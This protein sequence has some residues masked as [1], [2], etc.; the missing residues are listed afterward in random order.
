M[1]KY[2][3]PLWSF[4]TL[5]L[6]GDIHCNPGPAHNSA[7]ICSLC[8]QEVTWSCK[9]ICCDSCDIW[10]HHSCVNVNSAEY[11]LISR[12]TV[13]WICP[14]CDSTNCDSFTFRSYALD[15]TN[16][17]SPLLNLSTVDSITSSDPF[18]PPRASSP[19]SSSCSSS[20]TSPQK[21]LQQPQQSHT[22][23]ISSSIFDIP[24]KTNLR[25]LNINFQ[26]AVGKKQELETVLQ[27]TKPD[28]IIG[29]ESWLRGVQPGKQPSPD[30]I[31]SSEVFPNY[32][33][34]FRNDR[35]TRG[36]GVF[37]LTHKSLTA[38]EQPQLVTNCEV[39][40][41][42][43]K[44]KEC[45]DLYVGAFYM[46][47]RNHRD[48]D[49]LQ[50]S[51]NKLMENGQKQRDTIIAGD[52]NCPDIE[53]STHTA[54]STGKDNDIQQKLIDN[55]SAALLTQVHHSPTRGPNILDLVFTSNPTLVKSS[56]SIPGI[57]DHNIVVTDFDTRPQITHQKPRRCFKFKQANWAQMKTDLDVAALAVAEEHK[58]GKDVDTLWSTFKAHLSETM[59]T[60]IP[61]FEFKPSQSLPWLNLS[62]KKMLKR[63]KRL[64]QRAKSSNNWTPYRHFQKHC[65]REI[66]R[67]EWR[68]ING[69]IQEGLDKNDTKPF[70][71]FIKA[72]KQDNTGVA[73]L[74]TNGQLHSDSQSKADILLEQFKSVFTKSS[75]RPLPHLKPPSPD[76]QPITIS[77]PGVA[78]LLHQLKTNKASG[79]DAIPNIV[80]KTL[81]DTIAPILTIIY[82]KSIDTAQLP[83]DWLTAN[84]SC[85]FKKGDRHIAANYRPIS[86]TSVP[87][88]ILEHII[89]RHIMS[90]LENHQILT[91][92]NHGF[93]SGF[94]TETQLLTTTNDLLK[95][96][97]QGK[98]IDMAILDF[99][100][101]F[102]TVPHDRL[103]H[104]LANY[105]ITDPLLS[106]LRCFL[107]ER[108]MQVVVEGSTSQSTTVD[109]GVPQGTVLGPL[110][111]LCHIN[112]LPE[113]VQSQVRLFADDCLIYR[114]IHNFDDH[115]T[116]QADMKNLEEWA[117]KWGMRF[118]ATKCYIMSISHSPPSHFMYTL[119]NTILQKVST[120]P[121]LGI[122]FSDNLKWSHHINGITKKANSTL[123]FLRRNLPH[124]PTA[125]KRN[126][127]LALVRPLLEY[128]AIIW[129]P[130]QKQDIEKMER[131][132]R[133]AARFIARDF[134]SATPGFV[135]GLLTKY[136]LPTL[137][138]RR[139]Q[140][141][142]VFFYKVVEGL[143]PALPPDN[144]LTPQKPGRLIRPR[145]ATI[146][147]ITQNPV[148]SYI[149]NNNRC[150]SVP[151]CKTEQYRQSFFPRT[152]IAWNHLDSLV[153]N[154]PTTENFRTALLT[155]KRQK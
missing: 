17:F 37:I 7:A 76:I 70:W 93:R 16:Y 75:S 44:L 90:H 151:Y 69:T 46:P 109:S 47:E 146:D 111:F 108:S 33:N 4:I 78:K 36:G 139:E 14:R 133:T 99:S 54:H 3:H 101:A 65:K 80:L 11:D 122:Q 38:I 135:T 61:T 56:V 153:V 13:A 116:L 34:D 138:E 143:V 92:L 20:L 148:E 22:R 79:P 72:R 155:T 127:Y 86:L 88:K 104:K 105:G 123:G 121:Y 128:G 71:R 106:W 27:Y 142:L 113:T 83:Q 8:D 55:S 82:Q 9:G 136:N 2:D 95:S 40:W 67:A 41:I 114:E 25:V 149:R 66:R 98:Q 81:A 57:S 21:G 117:E 141:R 126:A 77:E 35:T 74:K 132:Q 145:R 24:K 125:C 84:V 100:K 18:S 89:F 96:F 119:N 64:F 131:T 120:N 52:F 97:D 112:D 130:Y 115:Y 29:T 59:E 118:N 10:F 5:L 1:M 87:C 85:A 102:D 73:P 60:N 42:K 137:Q 140:L 12:S 152:T 58:K 49:E 94:S 39:E 51:L 31:K 91:N 124:C 144:F 19:K 48:L 6:S 63:K 43:I 28:I 32:L 15:C 68:Y 129:D 53:W 154:S 107:T 26:S 30:R 103:L 50:K 62:L 23:S 134:R 110:L 45:K 150:Y 147:H